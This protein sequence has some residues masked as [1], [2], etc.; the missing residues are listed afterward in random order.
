MKGDVTERKIFSQITKRING[1]YNGLSERLNYFRVA[2]QALHNDDEDQPSPSPI[3]P[4][5]ARPAE[6]VHAQESNESVAQA[7]TSAIVAQ[8]HTGT[9]LLGAAVQSAKGAALKVWPRLVKH[10]SA[11]LTFVWAIIEANKVASILV[12]L[13]IVAG[14]LWLVYHNRKKLTPHVLR[15]LK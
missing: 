12:L 2:K 11:G 4:P 15:W 8:E 14:I 13:V 9:D 3:A 10:S 1:G 5:T 7:D 6:S